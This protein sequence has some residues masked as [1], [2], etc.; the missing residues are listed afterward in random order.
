MTQEDLRPIFG[1]LWPPVVAIASSWQSRAS[2]QIS[3]S[4]M[5]ASVVPTVPRMI[6]NVWKTNYTHDLIRGSGAFAVHLLRTDQMGWVHEFGFFSGR[7]R[8]KLAKVAH[9]IGV[10]GSPILE[11]ALAYLDCRVINTMDGGDM[12]CFLAEVVD[13]G[14]LRPG[15]LMTW[16]YCRTAMPEPWQEEL[17]AKRAGELPTHLARIHQVRRLDTSPP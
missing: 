12:T 7:E 4:A 9:H 16:E 6:T 10:S 3:I 13:G 8:D 11:E 1:V 17:A 5:P 2:V 14:F 15:E